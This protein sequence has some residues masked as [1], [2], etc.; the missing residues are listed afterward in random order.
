MLPRLYMWILT[1]VNI[2]FEAMK[3][4]L[5]IILALLL[6][7]T[8]NG[9]SMLR[10]YVM[11]DGH[12]VSG[13]KVSDGK[14]IVLTGTDGR[15]EFSSDKTSGLVFI[16]P[17]SGYVPVSSDGVRP[18]FYAHLSGHGDE[19][20]DFQLLAQDQ[21]T[22]TILFVTDIH[23]TSTPEKQDIRLFRKK[24]MPA[25]RRVANKSAKEGPVFTFNLGDLSHERY[26]YQ[27]DYNL[28]DAYGTLHDAGFPT[29]MYSVP[30]NHDNDCAILTGNT[31]WDAGHLYREV[32]GPEYYSVDIGGDHWLFM[33]DII[34]END[35]TIHKKPWPKGSVGSISYS[36]G[37]T[38]TQMEWMEQDLATT[39]SDRRVMICTHAPILSDN[40]RE[41]NFRSSQM[42]SLLAM[43]SR[44]GDVTVY[45]GHMHRM[46]YL[47][48]SKYPGFDNWIVSA[49]S[50]DMWESAPNRLL[51]IEGEDGGTLRVRISPEGQETAWHSHRDGKSVLRCYDLNRVGKIYASNRNIR[52]QMAAF[53]KR[54]DYADAKY[55]NMV[56]VNYWMFRPGETVS[57]YEDGKPLEV[58]KV[59]WEDPLFNV[60]YY[61]KSYLSDNKIAPSQEHIV[62][63]HMF[64][65]KASSPRSRLRIVV[66]DASG[67]VLH[68]ETMKRPKAFRP[69]MH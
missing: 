49:F 62:N 22:Y 13:V 1:V 68:E 7:L 12:P 11:C 69:R 27:N 60:S 50:G 17:P 31:D 4:I 21:S 25:F 30:G 55:R 47:K 65:A 24:A 63:R 20:H 8:L 66:T 32:F 23:L 44:F 48:G 41:T 45:A 26:W 43:L 61:L 67:T 36:K 19:E 56:L 33:D 15:Y 28:A 37:F 34:Y 2:C 42:D 64:A 3:K 46:Q 51:G 5:M 52:S 29:L 10:G 9:A 57:I 16:T 58:T 39:P 35:T 6:T 14:K 38:R 53:P 59:K 54:E 18:D 40:S